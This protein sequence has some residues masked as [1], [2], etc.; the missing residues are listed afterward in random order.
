M[1][2]VTISLNGREVAGPGRHNDTGPGEAGRCGYTDFMPSSS[3]E[4]RRRLPGMSC[5]GREEWQTPCLL[6]HPH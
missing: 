6:C 1:E 5:G 4:K 3:P 2:T